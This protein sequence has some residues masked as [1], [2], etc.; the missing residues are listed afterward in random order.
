MYSVPPV[1]PAGTLVT[2]GYPARVCHC[3][4][5]PT[6]YSR[7]TLGVFRGSAQGCNDRPPHSSDMRGIPTALKVLRSLF[8]ESKAV[9][10]HSVQRR[11]ERT[12]GLLRIGP[13]P[14]AGSGSG[15][16]GARPAGRGPARRRLLPAG[17]LLLPRLP[18]PAPAQLGG[19]GQR[20][21]QTAAPD[22]APGPGESLR[23]SASGCADWG[24]W[25]GRRRPAR[26]GEH[27]RE[28]PNAPGRVPDVPH[29]DVGGGHGEHEPR[30]AAV[31]DGDH[32]VG[33]ALQGRDLLPRDQVPHLAAAVCEGTGV[34]A[35]DSGREAGGPAPGPGVG[36]TQRDAAQGGL[37]GG[38]GQRPGGGRD[39]SLGLGRSRWTRPPAV[40]PTSSR[41]RE[42]W[43]RPGRS[44]STHLWTP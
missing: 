33:V 5:E 3:R 2:A 20:L 35:R 14:G 32:V 12:G 25:A 10:G 28:G 4:P 37:G 38:A 7:V 15:P 41:S 8:R 27:S 19:L 13:A 24:P 11:C 22:A 42:A 16:H 26:C 18:S 34:S 44:G 30:A 31:L 29:L 17:L 39:G 40:N 43:A 23:P 36:A 21:H 9:T 1:P 6:V